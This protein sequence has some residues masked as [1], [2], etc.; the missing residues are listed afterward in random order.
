MTPQTSLWA[1]LYLGIKSQGFD[2]EICFYEL[3]DS[4]KTEEVEE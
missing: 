1:R 2:P 3:K 4:D